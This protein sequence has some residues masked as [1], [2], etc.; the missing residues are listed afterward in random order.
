LTT[1]PV[2][3]ALRNIPV[4]TRVVHDAELSGF[5]HGRS[6][7]EHTRSASQRGSRVEELNSVGDVLS[8]ASAALGALGGGHNLL[9]AALGGLEDAKLCVVAAG[10]CATG[11]SEHLRDYL[12]S[13][14]QANAG[15][16]PSGS[17]EPVAALRGNKPSDTIRSPSLGSFLNEALDEALDRVAKLLPDVSKSPDCHPSGTTLEYCEALAALAKVVVL[18]ANPISGSMS[19]ALDHIARG[20]QRPMTT[21]IAETALATAKEAAGGSDAAKRKPWYVRIG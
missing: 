19:L 21:P 3:F 20:L 2:G 1:R 14:G 5:E 15:A 9:L 4:R 11:A 17:S 7:G 13:V 10:N 18:V 8:N 16:I 6:P 12:D